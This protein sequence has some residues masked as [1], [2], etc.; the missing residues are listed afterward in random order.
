MTREEKIEAYISRIDGATLQSIADR[1]GVT[2]EYLRQI[3]G[4]KETCRYAKFV[5]PNIANW[6]IDNNVSVVRF[7]EMI[8]AGT[9]TFGNW[10]HGKT[11]PSLTSIKSILRVTGMTFE[12]AFCTEVKS[13]NAD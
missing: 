13:R 4:T 11:E 1:Y 3:T 7:C 9:N 10:M 12:E 2:R 8:Y 5:F 6:L